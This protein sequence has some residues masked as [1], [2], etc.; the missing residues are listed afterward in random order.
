M[1][2][3]TLEQCIGGIWGLNISSFVVSSIP[4]LQVVSLILAISISILTLYK[5]N[6][7]FKNKNTDSKTTD[8]ES[9]TPP[10]QPGL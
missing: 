7:E 1:K 10:E 4:F 3:I 9:S 5:I 2:H 6:Q 8:N